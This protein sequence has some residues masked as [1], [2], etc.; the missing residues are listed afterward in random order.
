MERTTR[1]TSMSLKCVN[2]YSKSLSTEQGTSFRR[3]FAT[4][5]LSSAIALFFSFIGTMNERIIDLIC[6]TDINNRKQAEPLP[7]T[8]LT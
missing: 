8:H 6:S 1:R 7:A 3:I 2:P 4:E 5:V